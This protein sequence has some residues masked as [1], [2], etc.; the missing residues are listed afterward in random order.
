MEIGRLL[1]VDWA[2]HP[3]EGDKLL[4][5][6]DG[7]QLGDREASPSD[8]EIEE[9]R[10]WADQRTLCCATSAAAHPRH[11]RPTGQRRRRIPG[12]W[13]RGEQGVPGCQRLVRQPDFVI[14]GVT[15]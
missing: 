13:S 8:D 4:F 6:F 5:I 12:A 2:P 11:E 14:F 3:N 10:F 7:G 15:A 1:V 9:I